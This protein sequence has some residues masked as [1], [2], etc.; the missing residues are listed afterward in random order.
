MG[1]LKPNRETRVK[2]GEKVSASLSIE[3]DCQDDVTQMDENDIN[4]LDES[5]GCKLWS[6]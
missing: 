6:K 5:R 1:L 3:N 4:H 2:R